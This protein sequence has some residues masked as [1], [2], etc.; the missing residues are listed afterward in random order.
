MAAVP[1][2]P[3]IEI[4]S[5]SKTYKTDTAEIHALNGIDLSIQKGEIF[6]IIGMSGAGKSTLVRCINMLEKPTSGT[7]LFDGRDLSKLTD[8]EVRGAR[9]SMGM[10]FQQ[11][12]LL[13][14][15]TA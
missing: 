2:K 9:R 15:R 14:Q 8:A 12:N 4:R 6:G 5:L 7:V 10:I 11:F 13:M 3:I 1:E